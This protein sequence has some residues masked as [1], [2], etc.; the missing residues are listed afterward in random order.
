MS[1]IKSKLKLGYYPLPEEEAKRTRRFLQFTGPTSVLDPCAG[2][3]VALRAMTDGG[4]ARLYGIEL[5]A[6]RAAESRKIL[7]EVIH[8]SV[9]ETHC[10]VESFSMLYLN[11]PLSKRFFPYV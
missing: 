2:T 5:D 8:G 3:G 6:Y 9:F 4:E 7:D 10:P 11:P 1:R